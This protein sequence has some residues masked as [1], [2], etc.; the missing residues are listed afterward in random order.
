MSA[1]FRAFSRA[2]AVLPVRIPTATGSKRSISAASPDASARKCLSETS[3]FPGGRGSWHRGTF[4][5]LQGLR[6]ALAAPRKP[7][8]CQ[9]TKHLPPPSS[10]K[11]TSARPG[12]MTEPVR[13]RRDRC[14]VTDLAPPGRNRRDLVDVQP[15]AGRRPPF[16]LRDQSRVQPSTSREAATCRGRTIR[17]TRDRRQSRNHLVLLA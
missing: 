4:G 13:R 5:P 17:G 3:S 15:Q 9:E 11:R 1:S 2:E 12:A 6:S 16:A 8:N 7:A 14:L 10:R